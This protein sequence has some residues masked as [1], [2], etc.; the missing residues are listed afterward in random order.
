MGDF[1]VLAARAV[2]AGGLVVSIEPSARSFEYLEANIRRNHLSNVIPIR[3]FVSHAAGHASI[4][5]H[6]TYAELATNAAS[7]SFTV[8]AGPLDDLLLEHGV[9]NITIAKID[10]EGAEVAAIAG[11]KYLR[12]TRELAVEVHSLDLERE[13]RTVLT[14]MGFIVQESIGTDIAVRATYRLITH[15]VE[16]IRAEVATGAMATRHVG[17]FLAR[18]SSVPRFSADSGV[19]LLFAKR[20]ETISPR[21]DSSA[22]S[23]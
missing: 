23:N 21:I 1:T 6:G 20:F 4:T 22:T 18:R 3:W 9:S 19:R 7:G 5:E 16:I 15:P 2:G 11:Q 14:N 12:T 17:A 13:V 8:P 10:V